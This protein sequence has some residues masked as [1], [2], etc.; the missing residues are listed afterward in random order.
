MSRAWRAAPPGGAADRP[1]QG[2]PA[3]GETNAWPAPGVISLPQ[4]ALPVASSVPCAECVRRSRDASIQPGA[5]LLSPRGHVPCRREE[6]Q[7]ARV[8]SFF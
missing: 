3:T 4:V 1:A 8:C 6:R 5:R 7:V 2:T